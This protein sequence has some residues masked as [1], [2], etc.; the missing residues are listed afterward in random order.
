MR[1]HHTVLCEGQG[2]YL[3]RRHASVSS[4]ALVTSLS[5]S[6]GNARFISN[7]QKYLM[8]TTLIT[9]SFY[10][11]SDRLS[12]PTLDLRSCSWISFMKLSRCELSWRLVASLFFGRR[13][14]ASTSTSKS[15]SLQGWR[16][17]LKIV[18]CSFDTTTMLSRIRVLLLCIILSALACKLLID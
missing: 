2:S 8:A 1:I 10:G 4:D 9:G 13:F 7:E 17:E 18:C 5:S 16:L 12:F 11:I 14:L 3:T 15:K 6:K